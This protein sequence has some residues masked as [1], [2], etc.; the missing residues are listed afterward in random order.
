MR[1][2]S[3]RRESPSE[4][5]REESIR[6]EFHHILFEKEI[7]VR[8]QLFLVSCIV[9]LAVSSLPAA[10]RSVRAETNK[11][12]VREEPGGTSAKEH[13]SR[14]KEEFERTAREKLKEFDQKIK[15]LEMK[16]KEAGSQAMAEI[17]QEMHELREK[18]TALKSDIEKLEASSEK[19]WETAK[20]K[21]KNAMEE[22]EEAYDKTRDKLRSQ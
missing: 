15:D 7:K 10:V 6:K 18:R 21:V 22:L 1:I 12:T 16:T 11:T 14:E 19:T 8:R 3:R 17:K 4:I 9:F 2:T 13:F 20:Q 5:L